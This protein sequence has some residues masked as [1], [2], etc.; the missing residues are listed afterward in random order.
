MW[1]LTPATADNF[2]AIFRQQRTI[3]TLK[4]IEQA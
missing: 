1:L 3:I 4:V 2:V